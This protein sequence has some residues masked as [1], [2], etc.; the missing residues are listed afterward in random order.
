MNLIFNTYEELSEFCYPFE[1]NLGSRAWTVDEKYQLLEQI[2]KFY[3]EK[4]DE[5]SERLGSRY[6][7]LVHVTMDASYMGM[8]CID[9]RIIK[10][11]PFLICCH[12]LLLTEVIIHELT[13]YQYAAHGKRFYEL[14]EKNVHRLGMQD[15]FYGWQERGIRYP[16]SSWKLVQLVKEETMDEIRKFFRLSYTSRTRWKPIANG[17]DLNVKDDWTALTVPAYVHI[18]RIQG[19]L[20]RAELVWHA[21]RTFRNYIKS[22]AAY[23]SLDLDSYT[24]SV[25]NRCRFDL[26]K[27]SIDLPVWLI[28]MQPD[29]R[30]RFIVTLLTR[31]DGSDKDFR[32]RLE[33]NLSLTG[34]DSV[35]APSGFCL[36]QIFKS[37]ETALFD[38][39]GK[40]KIRYEGTILD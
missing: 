32:M 33:R 24:I 12:P 6:T 23:F 1:K 38:E 22:L 16:T 21:E 27:R 4:L 13:H 18:P 20:S 19:I 28:G 34:L 29:M 7:L 15:V 8:C 37:W 25:S 3:R 11:N 30:N 36:F 5:I 31:M 9:E 35:P 17:T 26:Q 40:Q 14:M 39:Q 2:A 10:L